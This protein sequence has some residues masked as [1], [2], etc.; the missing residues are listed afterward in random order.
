MINNVSN[1]SVK[2]IGISSPYKFSTKNF[3][4]FNL[5]H[6]VTLN[7]ENSYIENII[8]IQSN[9]NI[10]NYKIIKTP[11]GTSY[12]GCIFTGNKL[13]FTGIIN[14]TIQYVLNSNLNNIYFYNTKIFFVESINLCDYSPYT[15]KI[16][17]SSNIID[18][19][20]NK[21]NDSN[22]YLTFNLYVE[23]NF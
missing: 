9:I 12:D 16:T 1:S 11:I 13:F 14:T 5:S 8:Q 3:K 10:L 15:S 4:L 7:L 17:L 20:S 21:L 19:C 18:V 2:Y 23:A 6:L 22:I